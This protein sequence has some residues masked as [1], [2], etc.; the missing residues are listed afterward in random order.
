VEKQQLIAQFVA[1]DLTT[2]E[3]VF[4]DYY[5]PLVQYGNTFLKDADETEDVVQ[6]VF[7]SVWE[8]RAQ[9]EI[10]TSVRAFLYKAVH[11]ACLN[12]IKHYKIRAVHAEE[13]KATQTHADTSNQLEAD[14]LQE[15]I[16]VA[17]TLLPEQCAR[18][19][20]MSRFDHLKYQEIAD[21]L[22]LSVKTVENQMGKA[23]R[24]IRESLK[25]YLPLLILFFLQEL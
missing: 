12:R 16:H 6:Q 2:F 7:V 17:I 8:K 3:M 23:L 21:Q 20:K 1:G 24:I 14:E 19:F 22:G 15:K 5:Q 18:I 13:W 9:L 10:H 25:D 4:R 11:N